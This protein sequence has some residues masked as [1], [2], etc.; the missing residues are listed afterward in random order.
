MTRT[1]N[2]DRLIDLLRELFQLNQPDLDFGL[3]RILNA[4]AAEIERFLSDDV[5]RIVE[6]AFAGSAEDRAQEAKAAY[7][8]TLTQAKEFGVADPDASPKVK[9]AR[10]AYEAAKA[11]GGD[12]ADVYDDLYRFF[13]RYY[14]EGD[15][16]SRRYY[17]RE[18]AD[19]AA[20]YA[21]PYDGS[22]VYFH[23]ANKD[24]Y[25]IKTTENFRAFTFDAASALDDDQQRLF[26]D[27][28]AP[29]RVHLRV[30]DAA[31]GEHN[32]VKADEGK[33]RVYVI[34]ET[35]IA[36]EG[37]ELVVRFQYRPDPEKKGQAGKWRET[38]NEEAV[39]AVLDALGS[40]EH[41]QAAA[42]RQVLTREVRRGKD[43]RQP[44]LLRYVT[45]FT[46]RNTMDYFIHKDLGGFLR[47]ELDFYV[48]NEVMRLDD[49]EAADAP[50]VA[51]YL[52]K[53]RVLR[54]IAHAVIDFL[55]Q[56]EDF[57][58]RL[59]LK[60]KFVVETQYCLTLDRLPKA[61]YPEIAAHDAQREEWVRL[62]AIE[63]TEQELT[64]PGYSAPLTVEFL[65]ANPYLVLD[66][67]LFDQD[68]TAR[69]LGEIENLDSQCD[70]VL[71]HAENSQALRLSAA[72]LAK[73]VDATYIDP[74]YN[75]VHSK[76][77]YKNAY[78]HSSWLSLINN[79]LPL[80][81]NLWGDQFS[82]GLAI[83]DYEFTRLSALL[84]STFPGLEKST[85]VVNHHPQ[86]AGGRLSRTHEYYILLSRSDAP[87][88][89]GAPK[90]DEEEK[91]SFMRSGKAENNY[92]Y[93]RWQ[94]F[95]AL[96]VDPGT[97]KII[98]VEDPIPLDEP[99]PTVPTEEGLIRVYPINSQKE[100]RV[101]RSSYK[102]GRKRVERGELV[103]TPKKGTV[104][105]LIDHQGK[106]ETLFSNWTD[107]AFNAGIHG[108]QV[109]GDLGLAG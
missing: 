86:G 60:K 20:P 8:A 5:L 65:E 62:F 53:V 82:F 22:E 47:R 106:R 35:P 44:L 93:G 29:L 23:W 95:Y 102:T 109:L 3:Y 11:A 52:A 61:F 27:E 25:Y 84:D 68:F 45:R 80:L 39:E 107:S 104:Y 33:D 12:E 32:N 1:T 10:E 17:A 16:L 69:L 37:D 46:A 75:T 48:K 89:L 72:L 105:Q 73:R 28:D 78:E 18:T 30:V 63:E 99:Y 90:D 13:E 91:R 41:P 103:I 21:V 101:W 42:Y 34:A 98:G 9:E 71:I 19:R 64:R 79:T 31:E 51:T 7:E 81:R 96:L 66:T 4:R 15:F 87:T 49:L 24:Q 2:R 88:F 70:G 57:Q 40:D 83:D 6:E 94:S 14:D 85:V 74:P 26:A 43:G 67:A 36:W 100:E 56:T 76:I 77:A 38:R 92:R 97:R 59:W 58:K 50:R 108:T 55:A 54:R